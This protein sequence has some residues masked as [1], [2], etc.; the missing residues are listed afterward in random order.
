MKSYLTRINRSSSLVTT[1]LS[2]LEETAGRLELDVSLDMQHE[3]PGHHLQA[4]CELPAPPSRGLSL[5]KTDVVVGRSSLHSKAGQA[6][7]TGFQSLVWQV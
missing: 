2:T 5:L 7:E 6:S 4:M 1:S 3:P